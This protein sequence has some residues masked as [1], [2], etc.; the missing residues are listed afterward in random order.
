MLSEK[1]EI[2]NLIPGLRRNERIAQKMVFIKF[3][4]LIMS[5][6]L[7]YSSTRE[8]A[9]EI[10]NDVFY[11]AFSKIDLYNSN[12][13]FKNW[14]SRIAVNTSIDRYR[15]QVKN[16]RLEELNKDVNIQESEF[17][18]EELYNADVLPL[19]QS[20]PERY[21]LV[22]NM[23]VF[24]EYSHKEIAK[25][26]NISLGTS[27]SCLSRAKNLIRQNYLLSKQKNR[28]VVR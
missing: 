17:S 22:F 13:S 16:I 8:E 10:V 14:I 27:K 21:R 1:T 9:E 28:V 4:N 5:I 26:L 7:R 2:L 6:V 11:K 12:H 15:K 3:H 25:E 23:F 19:M 24:E 20:L 18:Y